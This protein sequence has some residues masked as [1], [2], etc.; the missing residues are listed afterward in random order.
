M[1]VDAWLTSI[2]WTTA[3]FARKLKIS[4]QAATKIRRGGGASPENYRKIKSLSR[5]KVLWDD[6][7]PRNR[8]K[9]VGE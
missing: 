4:H 2:G 5:M 6:I 1:T 3:K 8:K 7:Y 9:A